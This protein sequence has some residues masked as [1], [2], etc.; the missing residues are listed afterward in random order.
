MLDDA[1]ALIEPSALWPRYPRRMSKL[2][3]H[4]HLLRYYLA[5]VQATL[6]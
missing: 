3:I 4:R 2:P 6:C 1:V 5:G